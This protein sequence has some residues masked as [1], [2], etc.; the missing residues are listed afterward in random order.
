MTIWYVQ[1]WIDGYGSERWQPVTAE[2]ELL[3]CG[4][5]NRGGAIVTSLI[6]SEPRLYKDKAK[7]DRVAKKRE[8]ELDK[9]R[10]GKWR[11]V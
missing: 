1:K 5:V 3:N 7:A 11:K 2:E 4:W 6:G 8:A 10:K 9:T